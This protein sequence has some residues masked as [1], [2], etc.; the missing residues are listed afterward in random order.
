MPGRAG[1]SAVPFRVATLAVLAALAAL[2]VLAPLPALARGERA[3]ETTWYG[4]EVGDQL[5]GWERVTV[6]P[7]DPEVVDAE[8]LLKLTALGQ[9]F[10]VRTTA[11][12]ERDP[13]TRAPRRLEF[14]IHRGDDVQEN[15]IVFADGEARLLGDD[16]KPRKTLP[17]D[18]VLLEDEHDLSAILRHLP[19]D[20]ATWRARVLFPPA[21]EVHDKR[22]TREGTEEIEVAGKRRRAVRVASYDEKMGMGATLWADPMSGLVL[23]VTAANGITAFLADASV[24]EKIVSADFDKLVFAEV[25]VDIPN[26][27]ELTYMKVRA[28]LR[29][30]GVA[31]TAESLNVPGQRFTGKVH[32]NLVEG[33]F[34]ISWPRYDG[35]DAPP[36]PWKEA[37]SLVPAKYLEPEE[38]VESDDPEIVAKARELTAGARDAWDAA[39]RLSRF[40]ADEIAY[41]IPGGSAKHTL[42]TRKGECGAHS[43]LLVA[44]CRAVGIPAR[45][46]SGAVYNPLHNGSFGQHA[47]VELFMGKDRGWFPVD[48]TMHEVDY[49]DAG[50]L[51]LGERANFNPI[52]ME[53]L[54][55]VAGNRRMGAE[56]PT[57]ATTRLPVPWDVGERYVFR[58]R[59]R[60]QDAG[61]E[62]LVIEK[63][64]PDGTVHGKTEL[65][66]G[67]LHSTARW[68]LGPTG[69]PLE[70]RG[71]GTAGQLTFEM[72]CAFTWPGDG[73]PGKVHE[74]AKRSDREEPLERDVEL[75]AGA[76]ILPNNNFGL[77]SLLFA[78]APAEEG[79]S[80]TVPLFSPNLARV[81]TGDL[82]GGP[83]ETIEWN[84][85]RVETRK[86]TLVLAGIEIEAW[87]DDAGRMLRSSQQQGTV[88]AELV[89]PEARPD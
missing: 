17:M 22:W 9:P 49:C 58:Y 81:L 73:K 29:T 88:V 32:E 3:E 55:W 86:V 35:K 79:T 18:G 51:R 19:E 24:R 62:T 36:F 46:V 48:P 68:T 44:L 33:V 72:S 14:S 5:A 89:P 45:I 84:G 42:E 27:T 85:K 15:R 82:R 52:E 30:A 63:V 8:T 53:V 60:G 11:R 87:L 37:P 69:A 31:V 61:T 21:F 12:L 64:D 20:G 2:A 39:T 59:V 70:Y 83:R 67:V 16:G 6:R 4:I 23:K 77:L 38:M 47:W 76:W 34:E 7:G 26:Y 54:D 71:E 50:H 28:K 66:L 78:S 25:G 40:V 57:L 13:V 75:P 1:R 65:A 10:D 41:E 74:V 43:A 80:R 56:P